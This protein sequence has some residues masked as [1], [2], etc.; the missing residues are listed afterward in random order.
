M[1]MRRIAGYLAVLA[2]AVVGGYG[3]GAS[4]NDPTQAVQKVRE[5]GF[6]T[7]SRPM[8]SLSLND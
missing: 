5:A 2:L 3:A 6:V 1:S 7:A 4:G 8:E